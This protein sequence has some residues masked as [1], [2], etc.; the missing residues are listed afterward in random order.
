MVG[1]EK[2][3]LVK[4]QT[5]MNNSGRAVQRIKQYFKISDYEI[6]VLYDDNDLEFGDIRTTGTSA[7]GHKGMDSIISELGTKEIARVR[8]GIHNESEIPT[9]NFVL[10]E[11]NP[12]EESEICEPIEKA[13]K[14]VTN[15]LKS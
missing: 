10:Q 8:L 6:I 15:W 7:G 2:V 11:F 1:S 5:Y 4:P 13:A 9:E 14:E 12:R 3:L